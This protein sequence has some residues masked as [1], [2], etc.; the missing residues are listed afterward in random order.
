MASKLKYALPLGLFLVTAPYLSLNAKQADAKSADATQESAEQN[1]NSDLEGILQENIEAAVKCGDFA[2]SQKI[3]EQ[4]R[5]KQEAKKGLLDL[6]DPSVN[7]TFNEISK[8]IDK[9]EKWAK[10]EQKKVNEVNK[11]G[12]KIMSAGF[13]DENN[14]NKDLLLGDDLTKVKNMYNQ[15]E[16][17]TA[18]YNKLAENTFYAG[19]NEYGKTLQEILRGASEEIKNEEEGRNAFESVKESN[20]GIIDS[21]YK[22]N[23]SNL[24]VRKKLEDGVEGFITDAENI[25]NSYNLQSDGAKKY[26]ENLNADL[27]N[28]IKKRE[29]Q[30]EMIALLKE[31]VLQNGTDIREQSLESLNPEIYRL[32]NEANSQLSKGEVGYAKKIYKRVRKKLPE[33]YW[34]I[35]DEKLGRINGRQQQPATNETTNAVSV[36][37][38]SANPLNLEFG[39]DADIKA[40]NSSGK[41]SYGHDIEFNGA[42]LEAN[43][44]VGTEK[45][46]APLD[47]RLEKSIN[48]K[49]QYGGTAIADLAYTNYSGMLSFLYGLKSLKIGP[50]AYLISRNSETNAKEFGIKSI[51]SENYN[52]FGLEGILDIGKFKFDL[53]CINDLMKE[54]KVS[55]DNFYGKA[56]SSKFG[57]SEN[58]S[59]EA[60]II[61][62]NG[63]EFGYGTT[64]SKT[65]NYSQN[66]NKVSI[67]YHT[68]IP[69][70]SKK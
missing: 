40:Y 29:N 36:S 64:D 42:E 19:D 68:K 11:L 54:A 56:N 33:C 27:E 28:A 38:K 21:F 5:I 70:K 26:L 10:D 22:T 30:E 48:G 7:E 61:L 52:G 23:Y 44:S 55:S 39:A 66:Q 3:I 49:M 57:N 60:G 45:W 65:G 16:A 58:I 63:L 69:G 8:E 37:K 15:I 14:L 20:K 47:L 25:I 18:E 62:N 13:Y 6:N 9:Y 2:T 59:Y 41:S 24:E 32:V 51:S 34:S 43:V 1:A 4:L 46:M 53:K 17:E 35:I 67:G 50:S 31:S 12:F